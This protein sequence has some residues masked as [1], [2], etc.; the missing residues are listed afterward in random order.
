M[1]IAAVQKNPWFYVLD[2]PTR[3]LVADDDP[4]LLEFATV[5]QI[6]RAHV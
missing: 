5:H 1:S 4:I 6:G 2:E 3:V